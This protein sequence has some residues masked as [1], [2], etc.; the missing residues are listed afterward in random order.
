M[1]TYAH[2]PSFKVLVTRYI[3]A[4]RTETPQDA[5]SQSVIVSR[6]PSQLSPVDPLFGSH[7]KPAFAI[8]PETAANVIAAPQSC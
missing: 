6:K 8:E 3:F 2:L 5:L 7:I 4:S 1:R